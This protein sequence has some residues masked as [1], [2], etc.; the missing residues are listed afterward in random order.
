MRD[1]GIE[2]TWGEPPSA[3]EINRRDDERLLRDPLLQAP[4]SAAEATIVRALLA[5][6]DPVQVAAAFV[7][8]SRKG[9]AAPEDLPAAPVWSTTG[10]ASRS[11]RPSSSQEGFSTGAWIALSVGRTKQAEPRWL[12]PMLCKAG[13]LTKRQIGSIRIQEHQ[14]L[15]EI[16]ANSIDAFLA[17]IGASGGKLEKSIQVRRL[18]GAPGRP[19]P[20]RRA[21]DG[22]GSDRPRQHAKRAPRKGGKSGPPPRQAR[23]DRAE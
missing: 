5:E 23:R 20:A 14:T 1:A 9:Q 17:H 12:I 19:E 2:A 6:H 18:E 16:D 22:P 21:E 13:G 10:P 11:A 4:L 3:D 7:R 8:L 15:V